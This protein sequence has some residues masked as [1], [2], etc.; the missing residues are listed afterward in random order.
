MKITRIRP[1]MVVALLA[2]SS[3]KKN[4]QQDPNSTGPTGDTGATGSTGTTGTTGSTGSTGPVKVVKTKV[5]PGLY[6]VGYKS[7]VDNPI[8]PRAIM[9]KDNNP[10]VLSTIPSYATAMCVQDTDIYVAGV[11]YPTKFATNAVY[12]VNKQIIRLTFNSNLGNDAAVGIGVVGKDLYVAGNGGVYWK[13][14][15]MVVLPGERAKAT[16]MVIKGND[17]YICGYYDALT[18]AFHT[19]ACYWKNGVLY[20]TTDNVYESHPTAIA[21]DDNG[22]VYMSGYT[23][24][25]ITP[26]AGGYHRPVFWKNNVLTKLPMDKIS[27]TANGI[28]VDGGNIY[29]SGTSDEGEISAGVFRNPKGV[30]WKNGT[31]EN[32]GISLSGG[33]LAIIDGD[34]YV[35]GSRPIDPLTAYG[36][37]FKNGAI[38]SQGSI[39][40][41]N[42]IYVIK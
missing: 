12:W 15:D 39:T 14:G 3:C 24:G 32:L 25:T 9:W 40:S 42:N 38:I 16:G 27:A 36:V 5:D 30:L 26:Q 35:A 10:T 17:V 20:G 29:V 33:S 34:V 23:I 28:A 13:N 41:F 18:P 7:M 1:L 21:V 4:A 31:P 2:L 6:L 11:E 37:V 8:D 19:T 22:N